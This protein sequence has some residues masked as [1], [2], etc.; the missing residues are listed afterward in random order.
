MHGAVSIVKSHLRENLD[1]K[2][3]TKMRKPDCKPLRAGQVLREFAKCF[4]DKK[5][6]VKYPYAMIDG[7]TIIATD[8]YVILKYQH[9]MPII[10]GAVY[11]KLE[12]AGQFSAKDDLIL[13][14]EHLQGTASGLIIP[15]QSEPV[16]LFDNVRALFSRE[17]LRF[18]NNPQP[19]SDFCVT[20]SLL[21][22]TMGAFDRLGFES[23]HLLFDSAERAM[24]IRSFKQLYLNGSTIDVYLDAIVNYRREY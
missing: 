24:G 3:K 5:L 19:V 2:E 10:D 14:G 15:A 9:H 16:K 12:H 6:R 13:D 21:F 18:D 17:R 22:N 1:R 20:S 11:M 8:S 23:V 4:K 7:D